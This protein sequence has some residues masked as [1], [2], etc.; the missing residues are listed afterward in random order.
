MRKEISLHLS[1]DRKN[2]M[3]AEIK[4]YFLTERDE[5]IGDLAAG[6]LF[7]FI[8]EKLAPEFYNQGV[9]DSYRFMKEAAEDLLSIRV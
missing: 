6:M 8:R 4:N 5:E 9:D 2:E 3:I 7:D 1:Q